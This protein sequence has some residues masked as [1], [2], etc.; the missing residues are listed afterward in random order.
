MPTSYNPVPALGAYEAT[1]PCGEQP[2]LAY[3][4]CNLGS[5]NVGVF[6]REGPFD[7]PEDGI[8][9]DAFRRVVHLSVH[10]LDNVIDANR[11]PLGEIDDLAKQD[12]PRGARPDGLG[13]PAGAARRA[14]RL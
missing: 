11:Y 13:R 10:F 14:L 7:R 3:D 4:V 5:I 8:D 12:P 2:L 6:V 1:N 9:W